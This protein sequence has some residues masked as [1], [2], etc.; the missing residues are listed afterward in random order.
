MWPKW[1]AVGRGLGVSLRR[2]GSPWL[3]AEMFVLGAAEDQLLINLDDHFATS[4]VLQPT[5]G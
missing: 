1:G 3:D 2:P 5:T 4:H